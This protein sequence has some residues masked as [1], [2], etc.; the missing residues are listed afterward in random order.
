VCE[1][2]E[3]E[4][5]FNG[6]GHIGG[7]DDDDGGG[8]GSGGG[9]AAAVV[10]LMMMVKMIFLALQGGA[11]AAGDAP[12]DSPGSKANGQPVASSSSI[13]HKGPNEPTRSR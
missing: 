12:A 1:Y 9:G 3:R 6:D 11:A 13:T 4:L 7:D 5:C 8:G 2:C 10:L